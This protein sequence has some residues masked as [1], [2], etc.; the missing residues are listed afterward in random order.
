MPPPRARSLELEKLEDEV[1]QIVADLEL[2]TYYQL[3]DL[4]PGG[5]CAVA[6]YNYNLK[7]HEYRRIQ[8]DHRASGQLV[9]ALQLIMD[10]MDEAREVLS[11]ATLRAE[12]DEGVNN[13]HTRHVGMARQR[14]IR[15]K[16]GPV[17]ERQR[18][19]EEMAANLQRG[20]DR[21]LINAPDAVVSDVTEGIEE[22]LLDQE[23]KQLTGELAGY[24]VKIDITEEAPE[25]YVPIEQ[26]YL[27]DAAE[28]LR[29]K[30]YKDGAT[31]YE[32][33]ERESES[34]SSDKEMLAGL[35]DQ[36]HRELEDLGVP[37]KDE[38]EPEALVPDAEFINELVWKEQ[39]A[40]IDLKVDTS[41]K[42]DE[43]LH[44]R[45]IGHDLASAL[46]D[47]LE[48][49][50]ER[51]GV[52][53]KKPVREPDPTRETGP[54]PVPLI[55]MEDEPPAKPGGLALP[56][57]VQLGEPE[58]PREPP[59]PAFSRAGLG[60]KDPDAEVE[61]FDLVIPLDLRDD[62]PDEKK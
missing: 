56:K 5:S 13:G 31:L 1:A 51:M 7:V 50:L 20:M 30:I 61:T 42:E 57:A 25:Q 18:L 54:M 32:I 39:A 36:L 8:K 48:Q 27:E 49:D 37:E 55:L 2:Y 60:G 43:H 15:S 12:Y 40:V 26:D 41:I 38:V 44:A 47:E 59:A 3:L 9:Q 11:N 10:R 17:D 29:V 23:S 6:E 45:D 21:K 46:S 4:E 58:P 22:D 16:A 33:T 14:A 35:T 34:A 52:D 62:P 19:V 28:D 24:G 53:Y